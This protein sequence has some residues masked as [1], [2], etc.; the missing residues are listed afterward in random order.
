MT[1]NAPQPSGPTDAF[2]VPARFFGDADEDFYAVLG[3]VVMVAALLEDRLL[4]LLTVLTNAPQGQYAGLGFSALSKQARRAL[5][6]RPA[7]YAEQV[8]R[9]L[10]RLEVRFT[11]RNELVHSLWPSPTLER[12]WGHR[13][14]SINKRTRPEDFEATV[15]TNGAELAGMLADLAEIYF[16]IRRLEGI[17]DSPD[18]RVGEAVSPK[19]LPWIRPMSAAD[20]PAVEAIYSAGI[21]SGNA[22]FE[23][24]PPTWEQFDDS[25]LREHRLVA[26]DDGAVIGWAAVV[27]VSD[28]WVYRGVV[29]HSVYVHP[30]AAGRGVA[31][32]LLRVLIGSTEAAGIWTIQ[33]GVFPENVA[34]LA[35]HKKVGF[36]TVG[37]RKR[38]GQLDGTWRDV[39]MIERRSARIG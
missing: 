29:E 6:V 10:D 27:A 19:E 3:R 22:T 1:G 9:A 18:N 39:E 24:E 35:V 11:Q 8:G 23:T 30:H 25:K 13:A 36:R 38:V 26:V 31:T 37:A 7:A 17:A 14:V 4:T 5:R 20:W 34:S 15:E 12:A 33:A 32:A 16:E 2:G 21:A 28:R